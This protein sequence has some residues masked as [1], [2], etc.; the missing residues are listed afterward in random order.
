[1]RLTIY[2]DYALRILI[3]LTANRG[4]QCA[5]GE[6]ADSYGISKNHLMKVA[7]ELAS[8]GIIET[9][10]GNGGGI[11]LIKPPHMISIGDVVRLTESDMF[12][13][14]CFDTAGKGCPIESACVLAGVLKEALNAFMAVIDRYSVADL[15]AKRPQLVEL[16]GIPLLV[17][18]GEPVG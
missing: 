17:V 9:V 15:M 10:R 5:V 1:M 12:L 3:Y 14:G 18:N 16:L 11:K 8:A 13:V 7:Q 2:T 4:K 6:I